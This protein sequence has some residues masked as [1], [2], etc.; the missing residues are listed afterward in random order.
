MKFTAFVLMSFFI[1]GIVFA[2][3]TLQTPDEIAAYVERIWGFPAAQV[4]EDGGI[5]ITREYLDN[6][7]MFEWK[8]PRPGSDLPIRVNVISG[9]LGVA[10]R[11]PTPEETGILE[12]VSEMRNT[13]DRPDLKETALFIDMHPPEDPTYGQYRELFQRVSA[14]GPAI[15]LNAYSRSLLKEGIQN[16]IRQKPRI[17]V[18]FVLSHGSSEVSGDVIKTS[19]SGDSWTDFDIW[20]PI[21]DNELSSVQKTNNQ[22]FRTLFGPLSRLFA[23]NAVVIF[24]GCSLLQKDLV[25]A[26]RQQGQLARLLGLR[27]GYL[28]GNYT[29]SGTFGLKSF[30]N[31]LKPFPL[32]GDREVR[33]RLFR[34]QAV[35]GSVALLVGG[36]LGYYVYRGVPVE[37]LGKILGT[38]LAIGASAFAFGKPLM[39][40]LVFNKGYAFK[41]SDSIPIGMPLKKGYLKLLRLVER[42][43]LG[44]Q[45]VCSLFL[46]G[47][48]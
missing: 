44:G 3:D 47:K 38:N 16:I 17:G 12:F 27:N 36:I 29:W 35:M 11:E 19:L 45:S 15:Y 5:R 8:V 39:E 30:L 22:E 10:S 43:L 6:Q 1:S 20:T 24:S 9:P 41:I 34:V 7:Q 48:E 31:L 33:S 18:V 32:I 14:V 37:A 40:R 26:R 23:N 4:L 13:Y 42:K 21:S 25:L 2:N 46:T 28:F